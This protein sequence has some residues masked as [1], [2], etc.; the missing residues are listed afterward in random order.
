MPDPVLALDLGGTKIRAALVH[1]LGGA[2]HAGGGLG[3]DG[4]GHGSDGRGR[5]SD[6]S[7]SGSDGSGR[8]PSPTAEQGACPRLEQLAEVPTPAADGAD[9]VLDAALE[10]AERVRG[11][12]AV[13]VIGISSAGVV[14]GERGRITHATESLRGWAGTD[15]ATPFVERFA[16]PVAV[17]ND[18]HAHGVGEAR[19]GTGRGR[20][21]LLLMAVGTGIGGCHV[22]DGGSV[23]GAR[24]AAGH[25]GHVPAP[26]AEGIP[27]PCGRTGHLEGLASGPGIVRLAAALGA[28]PAPRDGR[29]LAAMAARGERAALEAYR[30]AGRATGRVLGAL[31]NVLDPEVVALTGGVADARVT[32]WREAV[33]AGIAQEAMDVVAATPVLPASAGSHAALLGAASRALE[34]SPAPPTPA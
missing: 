24:G 6:G 16:T 9:A 34:A 11:G 15:L 1:G 30:L 27:C 12:A 5:G 26:E 4:S 20:T 19:F 14:D 13:R 25:V 32:A 10:L 3:R 17:L 31:L 7:G 23:L 33:T 2:G 28:D 29:E 22:L 18:V 21:S 8:G